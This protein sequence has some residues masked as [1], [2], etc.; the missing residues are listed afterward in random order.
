MIHIFNPIYRATNVLDSVVSR[1]YRSRL[2]GSRLI[3]RN[4]ASI[5]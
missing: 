4:D 2:S 1:N 5:E 3:E